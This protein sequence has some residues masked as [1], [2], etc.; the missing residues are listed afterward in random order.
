MLPVGIRFTLQTWSVAPH[1]FAEGAALILHD[2]LCLPRLAITLALNLSSSQ[3][4]LII[5]T[6]FLITTLL[7]LSSLSLLPP[8]TT[9]S[10]TTKRTRQSKVNMLLTIQ[11]HNER[12]NIDDLL[13]DADMS[14]L[15]QDSG[16]MDGLGETE[17]V[18]AG[19]QSSLQEV[20]D[21]EGQY[22]IELHAGFVKD[23][24]T[25]ET[26]D[27]S[28]AFEKSFGVFFVEGEKLSVSMV[29]IALW[30][31]VGGNCGIPSSTSD[32]G[33]S[34]LHTPHLT[35]VAQAIFTNNLQLRV[36]VNIVRLSSVDMKQRQA[37]AQWPRVRTDE[38]TR[39]LQ[40]Y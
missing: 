10:P 25:D 19:L 24:D 22:V 36:S 1:A 3:H 20:F 27:E 40:S 37:A 32:F 2:P 39:M 35:L 18:H 7:S 30:E 28:V 23:T 12:R 29:S 16:V 13:P 4:L 26:A 9:R 14:L 33:Q 6:A 8:N 31:V 11:S 38:P 15:D 5:I 21:A 34:Q 17:L